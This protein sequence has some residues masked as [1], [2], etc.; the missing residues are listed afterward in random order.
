MNEAIDACPD[1]SIIIL[2]WNARDYLR[3]CL[4]S[5]EAHHDDLNI[6]IWVV[7]NAS[8]DGS[9]EMV[10]DEFPGVHLIV[11]QE[12]RGF[13]AGNNQALLRARGRYLMLLNPDTEVTPGALR[14]L[15][16]FLEEYPEVGVVGPRLTS[17]WGKVQGGAAGYEPSPWTVFNHAFLL[18]KLWPR[19]FRSIWLAESQYAHG[20]P[21]P[22]DWVSGAAMVIRSEVVQRVGGLDE[23]YFMYAED[24]EWCTRIRRAGWKVYCVPQAR[25]IHHIGGSARQ[26]GPGFHAHNVYSL[27]RYYRS[28]Y[29]PG[30]VWLIHLFALG[31]FLLRWASHAALYVL[32]HEREH[33]EQSRQWW[34]CVKATARSLAMKDEERETRNG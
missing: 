20:R 5:I 3:A 6:E 28:R 27:D 16:R 34:A 25:I 1:L 22:V 4:K 30:V 23:G 33:E 8:S 13:A 21:I 17:L 29:R 15:V 11:N 19:A 26:R 24:I 2:N 14:L 32:R 31:G 7:D 10:R 9:V 18:Y 12:N